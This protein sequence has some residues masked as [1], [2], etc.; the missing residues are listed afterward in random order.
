MY[1]ERTSSRNEALVRSQDLEEEPIIAI[2]RDTFSVLHQEIEDFFR[3]FGVKLNI[4]AD[5][6]GPPEAVAMAQHRV[7]ICLLAAS[8]IRARALVVAK[9]SSPQTFTRKC[10]LFMRRDNGHPA[11]KS[12]VNLILKKTAAWRPSE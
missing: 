1:A 4:V 6:F 7:G 10:A 12:F 5:A 8:H 11:L 2:A 3:D 9:P